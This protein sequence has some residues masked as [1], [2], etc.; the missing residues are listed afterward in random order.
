MQRKGGR[1]QGVEGRRVGARDRGMSACTCG[2]LSLYLS[3]PPPS[4]PPCLDPMHA[5]PSTCSCVLLGVCGQEH[6]HAHTHTQVHAYTHTHMLT[7]TYS[8]TLTLRHRQ[9]HRLMLTLTLTLKLT[10]TQLIIEVVKRTHA[11]MHARAH[12]RTHG[13]THNLGCECTGNWK[14]LL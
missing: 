7:H 10:L 1:V 13:H 12:T 9:R 14:K 5:G 4:L 6:A 2:S 8:L 3:F 11:R